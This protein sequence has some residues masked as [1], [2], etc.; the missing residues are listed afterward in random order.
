MNHIEA[1]GNFTFIF[2][3]VV[4]LVVLVLK[5]AFQASLFHLVIMEVLVGGFMLPKFN[6]G[7]SINMGVIYDM[8]FDNAIC[9]IIFAGSQVGL[10]SNLRFLALF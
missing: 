8:D 1:L 9:K 3:L 6:Q 2:Q 5:L 7:F 10:M 4:V